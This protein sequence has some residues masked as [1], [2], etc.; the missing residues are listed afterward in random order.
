MAI[1]PLTSIQYGFA[2]I[3]LCAR[4]MYRVVDDRITIIYRIDVLVVE[5]DI[6]II[7]N[8][9]NSGTVSYSTFFLNVH[10]VWFRL[11]K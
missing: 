6:N 4:S 1:V 3:T 5:E 7:H 10:I 2:M 8:P 11:Q 9:V